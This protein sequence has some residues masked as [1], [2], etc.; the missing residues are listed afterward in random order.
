MD[1]FPRVGGISVCSIAPL[2]KAH[3]HTVKWSGVVSGALRTVLSPH[4]LGWLCIVNSVAGSVNKD[5]LP[6]DNGSVGDLERSETPHSKNDQLSQ[7]DAEQLAS[8][9]SAVN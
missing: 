1:F 6:R 2:R 4:P 5:A 3:T 9:C 8:F 7:S